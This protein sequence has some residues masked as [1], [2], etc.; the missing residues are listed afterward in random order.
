MSFCFILNIFFDIHFS[1]RH[2]A[3]LC[4][5]CFLHFD[6]PV[7]QQPLPFIHLLPRHPNNVPRELC[8][9]HDIRGYSNE[10]LVLEFPRARWMKMSKKYWSKSLPCVRT[11]P[12]RSKV[13]SLAGHWPLVVH[14]CVISGVVGSHCHCSHSWYHC[15]PYRTSSLSRD[16]WGQVPGE[17]CPPL[18]RWETSEQQRGKMLSPPASD[19]SWD[20]SRSGVW[21]LHWQ[22][23]IFPGTCLAKG[24]HGCMTRRPMQP[25]FCSYTWAM[26]FS[27]AGFSLPLVSYPPPKHNLISNQISM[28]LVMRYVLKILYCDIL[29]I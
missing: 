2:S 15:D 9:R 5:Y 8:P 14:L 20:Q 25:C 21:S 7:G 23:S 13:D 26:P 4:P 1:N 11:S 24:L 6:T 29:W 28:T 27:T 18:N 10:C 12:R 16:F 3:P 22:R 17:A 19:Q